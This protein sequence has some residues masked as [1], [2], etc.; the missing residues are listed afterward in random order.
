MVQ[1]ESIKTT[2]TLCKKTFEVQILVLLKIDLIHLPNIYIQILK[3]SGNII[4][5]SQISKLNMINFVIINHNYYQFETI[6]NSKVQ[7]TI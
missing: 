2:K 5:L 3:T 7:V 1:S 4:Q 6:T